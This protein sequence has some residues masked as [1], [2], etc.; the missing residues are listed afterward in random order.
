[1][2]EKFI[3]GTDI[4][5]YTLL[6]LKRFHNT[7]INRKYVVKYG[8][9]SLIDIYLRNGFKVKLIIS[10]DSASTKQYPKDAN[11]ILELI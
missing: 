4:P 9:E 6:N 1:M 8:E 3:K 10:K 5:I 2:G 7:L 11:Y